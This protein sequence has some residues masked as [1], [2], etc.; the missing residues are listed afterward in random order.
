MSTQAND[1][2]CDVGANFVQ[3]RWPDW[4]IEDE[5]LAFLISALILLLLDASDLAN[6]ARAESKSL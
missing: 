4:R 1:F 3:R 2:S 5:E 6:R